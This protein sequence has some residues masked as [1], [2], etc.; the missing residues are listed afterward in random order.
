MYNSTNNDHQTS[1]KLYI[2]P[3]TA[4][5]TP[6]QCNTYQRAEVFYSK[7]QNV[8]HKETHYIQRFHATI[9]KFDPKHEATS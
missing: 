9:T 6:P 3:V 8:I 2:T 1:L 7:S 4:H 5:L